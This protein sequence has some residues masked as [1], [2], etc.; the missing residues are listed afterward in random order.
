MLIYK[1]ELGID[2]KQGWAKEFFSFVRK[3]QKMKKRSKSRQRT[4]DET[5][6]CPTL[7]QKLQLQTSIFMKKRKIE[8]RTTQC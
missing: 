5:K 4:K 1:Y 8:K 7:M 6:F 2:A 3:K